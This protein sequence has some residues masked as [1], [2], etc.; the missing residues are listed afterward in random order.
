MKRL[1]IVDR[2]GVINEE[3]LDFIK[4]PQEWI[5][6]AGSLEAITR[7]NHGGYRVVIATN[8]SGVGRRKFDIEML[9]RIHA[10]MIAQLAELGGRIDAIFFC[11]HTPRDNCDC[12][13]PKPGMLLQI[14]ERLRI[15]LTGV[16][17]VG[18]SARD[19]QAAEAAGAEPHLV[20]TGNGLVTE[21]STKLPPGT[22]VH[23]DL[24]AFADELL[25]EQTPNE[26]LST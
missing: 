15:P 13:K 19:L 6:I 22:A 21:A 3:S 26:F 10:L 23:T 25:R 7:L 16:P 18:D 20:L 11:P 14:S 24:A 17:S 12:R 8:Q 4:T 1:V 5:P 2:D 9:N